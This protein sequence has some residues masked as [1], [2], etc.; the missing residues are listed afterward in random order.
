MKVMVNMEVDVPDQFV[1][2]GEPHI[3]VVVYGL[4]E[5][6]LKLGIIPADTYI[7][8]ESEMTRF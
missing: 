2:N 3:S 1:K 7:F 4:D 8:K 5:K 6:G